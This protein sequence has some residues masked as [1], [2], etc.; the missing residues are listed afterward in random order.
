M[1]RNFVGQTQ[2]DATARM[3]SCLDSSLESLQLC[4]A[5]GMPEKQSQVSS[6]NNERALQSLKTN[7]IRNS[8]S[9]YPACLSSEKLT[10]V[11]T[12]HKPSALLPSLRHHNHNEDINGS[13]SGSSCNSNNTNISDISTHS[14]KIGI[15]ASSCYVETTRV[16]AAIALPLDSTEL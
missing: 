1:R 10:A 6:T 3:T 9:S 4:Q 12:M 15:P 11:G 8:I 7:V 2:D 16:K 5:D 14:A 13:S